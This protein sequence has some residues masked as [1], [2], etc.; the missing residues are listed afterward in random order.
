MLIQQRNI[1]IYVFKY[2]VILLSFTLIKQSNI[3]TKFINL[4]YCNFY[5][6]MNDEKCLLFVY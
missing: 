4:I 6:N 1:D 5:E 2:R 3:N